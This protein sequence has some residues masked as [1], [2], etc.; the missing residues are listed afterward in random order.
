[1]T[2]SDS[3]ELHIDL[4]ALQANYD[5]LAREAKGAH[6][7]AVVKADGYGLGVEKSTALNERGC[8][9]F[10]LPKP[11]KPWRLSCFAECRYLCAERPTRW[12]GG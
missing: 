10:L 3:A 5:R 6:C 12:C 4:A 2:Y 7:A 1:M 9:T 11:V 8:T